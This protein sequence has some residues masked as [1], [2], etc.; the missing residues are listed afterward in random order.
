MSPEDAYTIL[1]CI[2]KISGTES[3]LKRM[4]PEG[5]EVEDIKKA[6]EAEKESHRGPF[7]FSSIGIKPG[8]TIVF[9]PNPSITA[10]VVDDKHIQMGDT[11]TSLSGAA[12]NILNKKTLAGPLYWS[13]NVKI[14]NDIRREMEQTKVYC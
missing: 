14:L 10:I 5:H 2:A 3:K 11:V 12:K 8:E 1:D 6:E 9:I 4:K 7:T 13:Y